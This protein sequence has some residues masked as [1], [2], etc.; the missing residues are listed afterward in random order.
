VSPKSQARVAAKIAEDIR[1]A[2]KI[3]VGKKEVPD[4]DAAFTLERGGRAAIKNILPTGCKVL[5]R[6]VLEHGGLAWGRIYEFAGK[7]GSGKTTLACRIMGE[8]QRDGAVPVL[9]D[10]ENKFQAGWAQFHG[11][12]LPDCVEYPAPYVEAYHD[13]L[14]RL[15]NKHKTTR[16]LFVLDSVPALLPKAYVDGDLDEKDMPGALGKA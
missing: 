7:E 5:D 3:K 15:L 9:S 11:L 2:H 6:H 14:K 13:E 16:F 12:S 1:Q 10:K 4:P 8:A